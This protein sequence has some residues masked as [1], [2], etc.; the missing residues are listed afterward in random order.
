MT[1]R[2]G[3]VVNIAGTTP[4]DDPSYRYKMPVVFGKIEGKGNGIKTVI[5]NITEVSL[6]LHRNPG[7]VNKFFGCELGA[8]TTY[9]EKDD[10]AVVNGQHNDAALQ[11]MIHKYIEGFV[12]CPNCGLPETNYK[13]KNGCIW[14][15]C[16]AC[17]SKELVDMEHKLCTYIL[18]QDKKA[19]KEKAKKKKKDKKE[20]KD[21]DEEKK[22]KKKDKKKKN[23]DG[24]DDE[25]KDKKKKKKEKKKDK[26]KKEKS[27][28]HDEE[29]EKE[30]MD[31][32]DE[33]SLESE[34][35]DDSS[36]MDL[37]VEGV[38]LYLK[39]NPD[40]TAAE[41][42]EVVVNQQMSSAL[43]SHDKMLIFMRAAI[44]PSFFKEKQ[45]AKYAPIVG[46]ITLANPI[47]ERHLI[48]AVEFI[49]VEKPRNFPV[50]LKQLY[51]EEALEEDVI[52]QWAFDSRSEYTVETVDEEKR[53]MLRAE[54]EPFI[55]WLQD[56]SD[57]SESESE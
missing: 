16:A 40:S 8:Q 52:L 36:A 9:N 3:S 31:D 56:A 26:K 15:K 5:P 2:P 25:K 19:K 35:V 43:K 32:S 48:G 20:G 1:A 51:D 27:L 6:S 49:C 21:K 34:A 10:R 13:I 44:T 33:V 37:A 29:E 39:Q 24:D 28:S 54:A 46:K 17:G 11:S 14:H 45:I 12:L 47:M 41:V 38:H 18:A 7:E 50:M 23:K 30:T 22:D 53:S 4:V 57:S 55:A 42:T